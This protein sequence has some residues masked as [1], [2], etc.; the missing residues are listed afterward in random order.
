[1][2]TRKAMVIPSFN[3][4]R[5]PWLTFLPIFGQTFFTG[6]LNLTMSLF[7]R[8]IRMS[9]STIMITLIRI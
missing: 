5:P 1:M 7:T 8:N 2:T 9:A 4:G 3:L 6:I